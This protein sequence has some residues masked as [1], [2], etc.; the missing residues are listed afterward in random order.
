MF[1]LHVGDAL[2]GWGSF[3][4]NHAAVRTLVT[5]THIGGLVAGG[6]TAVA[7]DRGLLMALRRTAGERAQQLVALARAH[8]FVVTSLALVATSGLLLFAS[9]VDT[10]LYSRFFWTKMTLVALLI[11]NGGLMMRAERRARRGDAQAWFALRATATASL[12]LWLLTTLCGVA[13]PN[14]G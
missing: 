5:F 2:V 1:D 7:T 4:A 14:I 3:Y 6:G 11:V 12:A 8:R 10:F 13:L 9:D